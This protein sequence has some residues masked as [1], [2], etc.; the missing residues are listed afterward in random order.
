MN[1]YEEIFDSDEIKH[2][3]KSIKG[4]FDRSKFDI[5]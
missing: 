1:N 4:R 5:N 2:Y 3:E